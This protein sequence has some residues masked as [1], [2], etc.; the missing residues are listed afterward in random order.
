VQPITRDTNSYSGLTLSADGKTATTV[1]MKRTL[2]L[3][4]LPASG[5]SG[6]AAAKSEIENVSAFDWSL[7]GNLIIS[8]G[9]G[10]LQVRPDGTKL[11]TLISDPGGAVVN[12]SRCGD[13]Y[14]VHWAYRTGTEGAT[15]WKINADG[16]NAQQLGSGQ[17]NSA[18]T[19]SPD[20]KWVYYLD[21]L[22]KVMRVPA[23]GSGTPEAVGGTGIPDEFEYLGTIDFS[24]DGRRFLFIAVT[25]PPESNRQ[26]RLNLAVAGVEASGGATPSILV[27]DPRFSAGVTGTSIYSG[28]PRFSPDG[29]AIVYD[30]TDK[31]VANLWM[32]PLDGS[33]G[34]LL[35]NFTSG[36]I[37]GFRWSPD[38]KSLGVMREQDV[39]DVVVLRETEE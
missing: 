31:G 5:L 36:R 32:Q 33:A 24:P 19:C 25:M 15:I 7:D 22:A 29:K 6:T 30:I 9:S 21:T 39:S 37:N 16:S 3:A 2:T 14:L 18:P 1:Q 34:H 11:K 38:G 20:H 27:H 12:L 35:T 17:S 28:G 4:I 26:M 8:D 23:D 10:L 13:S